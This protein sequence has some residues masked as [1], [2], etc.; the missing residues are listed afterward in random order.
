[1]TPTEMREIEAKLRAKYEQVT[2]Y[3][4]NLTFDKEGLPI[5]KAIEE[6]LFKNKKDCE[7]FLREVDLVSQ[8][9]KA[10]IKNARGKPHD[11]K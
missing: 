7:E 9:L 8:E 1:M 4:P 10:E 5:Y 2:V 3:R 6:K 11:R